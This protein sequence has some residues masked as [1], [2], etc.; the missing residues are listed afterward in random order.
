MADHPIALTAAEVP[1]RA[2]VTGCPPT[3][4]PR[5]RGGR[6]GCWATCSACG[7]FGVNLTRLAPGAASSLRHAHRTQDE[8]VYILSGEPTLLTDAGETPLAPG[9]CAGFAAGT[10]DAHC[11][12][13]RSARD[14]V[15]L[16]IGD[17]SPATASPTPMTTSPRGWATMENG[18]TAARTARRSRT[19]AGIRERPCRFC[20]AASPMTSRA[21]P[22]SPTR[23][24]RAGMTAVQV[25]GVPTGDPDADAVIIALKSRTAPV[26]RAVD[27]SLA[28]CEALLAAGA[29]QFF[30]K[31]CSTFD[32]TDDG[33]IGPVADALVK[34]LDA[35]FAIAC[36]AFPTNGRTIYQGHL[37]VGGS[38][39][40]ESGMENHPLTPMKDANLVR[41]LGRQTDGAVGLVSATVEQGA[42]AIRK[43]MTAHKESGRR[44]AIVDAITDAH[45]FAIGEAVAPHALV[46]SS[47]A[48]HSAC[49]NFAP[50]RPASRAQRRRDAATSNRLRGGSR[51]VVLARDIGTNRL[52]A[53]CR[54]D[55]E[56]DPLATTDAAALTAQALSWMQ[57][58]LNADRPLSLPPASSRTRS[59]PCR[60]SSAATRPARSWNSPSPTSPRRWSRPVSAAWSSPVAR[61]LA[62]SSSAL[63]SAAC[64]SG[65]R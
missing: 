21:P 33:N 42:A 44:Y 58:K 48:W 62:A 24:S 52:R 43:A 11:L 30:W 35:G 14:V 63:A 36:P 6:S 13:N 25:I 49:R 54:A 8:F 18:A 10:G 47:S 28:A 45:L 29:R 51:G 34:K 55:A 17:R 9:M 56:I 2:R 53:G 37:F 60:Q 59:R 3:S 26:R 50:C 19:A 65:P 23:W 41:V 32:S 57:G 1:P 31:Y 20:L 16:E 27:E 7:N 22:T 61:P 5:W 40:S 15:Y 4:P 39:L 12:V 38:L 64:G 46:T